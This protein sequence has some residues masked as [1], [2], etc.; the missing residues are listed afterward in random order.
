MRGEEQLSLSLMATL[1]TVLL[2][3]ASRWQGRQFTMRHPLSPPPLC[4]LCCR[5]LRLAGKGDS[6]RVG[7]PSLAT[8]LRTTAGFSIPCIEACD[9]RRDFAM[10]MPP[11]VFAQDMSPDTPNRFY[12]LKGADLPLNGVFDKAETGASKR[13]C[14]SYEECLQEA[15][16]V[17]VTMMKIS[18]PFMFGHCVKAYFKDVFAKYNDIFYRLGVAL[19]KGLR[20]VYKVS[21]LSEEEKTAIS[22]RAT[23]SPSRNMLQCSW[24]LAS[25][26]ATIREKFNDNYKILELS[27]AI[28]QGFTSM[29]LRQCAIPSLY[30]VLSIHRFAK[31]IFITLLFYLV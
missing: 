19:H 30:E 26:S 29:V 18:D 27:T 1:R 28:I 8:T 14:K 13:L 22:L 2:A 3:V 24:Q 4:G 7:V 17:G 31:R 23:P 16:D 11:K 25:L 9:L 6:S 5:P 10:H 21:A 15:K 20:D 12:A